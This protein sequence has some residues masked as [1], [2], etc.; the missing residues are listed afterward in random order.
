[1]ATV[2]R[3]LVPPVHGAG[4]FAG[5]TTPEPV[6]SQASHGRSF[7]TAPA[8]AAALSTGLAGTSPMWVGAP[9]R[10]RASGL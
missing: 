4:R 5:T 9:R 10:M 6:G 7:A 8:V 3:S 2:I 1:M